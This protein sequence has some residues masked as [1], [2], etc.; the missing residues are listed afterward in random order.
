M[1]Q[2]GL[3]DT[4]GLYVAVLYTDNG[5]V[6]SRNLDW[7]YHTINIPVGII[8]SYGLAAKRRII[9]HNDLL[10]RIIIETDVRGGHFYEVHWSGMLV[11]NKSPEGE[12]ILRV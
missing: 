7:L 12:T 1:A 5:M 4:T 9:N 11:P 3:G 2:D 8:R 10:D 6:G